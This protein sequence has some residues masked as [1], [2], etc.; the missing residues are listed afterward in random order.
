[1]LRAK[2]TPSLLVGLSYVPLSRAQAAKLLRAS[3]LAGGVT[4]CH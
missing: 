3:R 4:V 1:M 2:P